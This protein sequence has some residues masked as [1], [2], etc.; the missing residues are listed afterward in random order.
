[1][2]VIEPRLYWTDR[3]PQRS[4]TTPAWKRLISRSLT[5][6]ERVSL[7]TA[8]FKSPDD[9]EI[10]EVRRL[11]G[12]DAQSFVDVID[13]VFPALSSEQNELN[14]PTEQTLDTLAPRLRKRCLITLRRMCGRQALLPRSLQVPLCY[15]RS[16]PPLSHGGYAD[17]WKGEH[18]GRHV[19]VKVLRV[20]ST[21][22]FHEI[23]NVGFRG[24]RK[25]CADQ[26]ML[27]IAEALQ[28]DRDVENSSPSKRAAAVGD[29]NG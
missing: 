17:V 16:E 14:C 20:H 23:T 25:V 27:A 9:N 2:T 10:E 11:C 1:M 5:T 7:I 3:S 13:E 26:L 22:E 8:I 18:Q 12:D 19:E 6:D 4:S 28:G 24:C 21:S 15:T 29:N